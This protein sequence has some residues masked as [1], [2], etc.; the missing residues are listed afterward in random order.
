MND[1]YAIHIDNILFYQSKL[2]AL[3]VQSSMVQLHELG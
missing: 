3:L 1:S 2:A